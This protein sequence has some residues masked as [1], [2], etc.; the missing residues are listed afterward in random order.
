[1]CEVFSSGA[2]LRVS[3]EEKHVVEA[4]EKAIEAARAAADQ[5]VKAMLHIPITSQVR[6][7]CHPHKALYLC[8]AVS[9][10]QSSSI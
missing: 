2:F 10:V 6:F 8:S 4:K 5:K 9:E 3:L 7:H 1:V